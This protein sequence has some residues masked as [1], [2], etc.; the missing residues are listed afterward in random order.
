MSLGGQRSGTQIEATMIRG[1]QRAVGLYSII[2][3]LAIIAGSLILARF[4]PNVPQEVSLSDPG[5][6][7]MVWAQAPSAIGYD[8]GLKGLITLFFGVIPYWIW[9]RSDRRDRPSA[10][11]GLGAGVLYGL[12]MGLSLSLQA[13]TLVFAARGIAAYPEL[14]D[15]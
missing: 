5:A 10:H 11:L 8:H 7:A 15:I 4:E 13:A 14:G 9:F 2:L 1:F 12:I 3:P 6:Q